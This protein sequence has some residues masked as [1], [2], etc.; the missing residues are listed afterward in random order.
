MKTRV[1]KSI[2]PWWN[3][4]CLLEAL[5]AVEVPQ[6]DPKGPLR[7]YGLSSL[8]FF[9]S[10]FLCDWGDLNGNSL[11][12]LVGFSPPEIVSYIF[13]IVYERV[14]LKTFFCTWL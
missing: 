8:F 12:Y 7:Y 4:S 13:I 1:D 10:V 11:A 3:G 2:C 9:L 14:C 5:D 6:R